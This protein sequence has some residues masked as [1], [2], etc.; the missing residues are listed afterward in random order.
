MFYNIK[1]CG[2]LI[3]E[4]ENKNKFKYDII[5][6]HRCDIINS[7][8]YKMDDFVFD[9]EYIKIPHGND[10]RNG[11][12]G[13]SMFGSNDNMKYFCKLYD[14]IKIQLSDNLMFHPENMIKQHL[15]NKNYNINIVRYEFNFT[16]D[17]DR[18]KNDKINKLTTLQ[19]YNDIDKL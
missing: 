18:N 16:L 2:E 19:S 12:N 9:E 6:F 8:S 15:I 17:T 1:K 11:L 5:W 7:S 10:W 4:Y 3:T 13:L 14:N